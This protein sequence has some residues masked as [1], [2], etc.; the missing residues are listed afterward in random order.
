MACSYGPIDRDRKRLEE[1]L[2]VG[3][4]GCD[5]VSPAD[6]E[7]GKAGVTRLAHSGA[8]CVMHVHVRVFACRGG[9]G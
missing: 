6:R 8:A 2:V 7:G 3:T 4:W 9:L 5:V 1:M